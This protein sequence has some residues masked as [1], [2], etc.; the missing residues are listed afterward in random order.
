MINKFGGF[1]YMRSQRIAA[2]TAGLLLTLGTVVGAVGVANAATPTAAPHT[3]TPAVSTASFKCS[4]TSSESANYSWG[5]G[6]ISTTV[7]YNN[8]CSGV[9][10]V[11]ISGLSVEGQN[12]TACLATPVGK[13]SKKYDFLVSSIRKGC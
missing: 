2:T 6:T 10:D 13:S 5:A 8:H 9:L 7:Y 12:E 3:V 4:S 1:E 11:S